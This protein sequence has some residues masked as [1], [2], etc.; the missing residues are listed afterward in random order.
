MKTKKILIIK[1]SALGD[2]IQN[3]GIVRAIRNHHKD[4]HITILTTTPY[5]DL[6]L[7]SDYIDEVIIDPRPKLF[8]ITKWINLYKNL[9]KQSFD[10][11]YDLQ[12]NDRTALYYKLLKTKPIWIGALKKQD[13]D[14][15]DFAFYRHKKMLEA[16]GIKGATIDKMDWMKGDL[17]HFPLQ[18]PYAL[19]VPGCA[20]TRPEKRWPATHYAQLCHD[21]TA[22]NIQPVLLG[23]NDEAEILNSIAVQCPSALNLLGK[24]SLYDI[25]PLARDAKFAVGNDTGPMHI[26][27]P[28]GCPSLVLFSGSSDPNKHA[29]LGENIK[30]IQKDNIVDISVSEV[31]ENIQNLI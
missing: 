12:I 6:A 19:I 3:L 26:I 10:I 21:L 16:H 22:L 27:G 15:S 24:T 17:S 25:A 29:P 23:T 13:R 9:N 8:Q 5:K 31:R 30:T 1:L 28:T 7:K 2:F 11:V 14:K 18:K 20:P 4:A